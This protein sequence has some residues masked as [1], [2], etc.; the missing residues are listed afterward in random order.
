LRTSVSSI[1]TSVIKISFALALRDVTVDFASSGPGADICRY[2]SI[3]DALC[4]MGVR[5]WDRTLPTNSGGMANPLIAAVSAGC[6]S[7]RD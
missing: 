3:S 5:Y 1:E 2:G 4:L 6:R 7:V